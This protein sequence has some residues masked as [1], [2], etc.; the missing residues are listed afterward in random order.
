[1]LSGIKKVMNSIY[2]FLV[3]LVLF[4]LYSLNFN[5]GYVSMLCV[6]LTSSDVSKIV[7]DVLCLLISIVAVV[8][9]F[10]NIFKK[11]EERYLS[12][13]D[14][15]GV[16]E[17]SD[18]SMERI[19][20]NT[21]EKYEEIVESSVRAKLKNNKDED[22][23]INVDIKCGVDEEFCKSNSNL[24]ELSKTIQDDVHISL[25]NF[26]GMRVDK[27]NIII[28]NIKKRENINDVVNNK[29]Y[30]TNNKKQSRVK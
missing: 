17:I 2:Y 3:I 14:E 24:T 12:L 1:M 10:L 19:A 8:K 5:L 27:V 16:I 7:V 6:K 21:L 15:S 23:S 30:G 20:T 11:S 29:N 18:Y 22:Y 25:E 9:I 13:Y 4:L 28:H 26:L